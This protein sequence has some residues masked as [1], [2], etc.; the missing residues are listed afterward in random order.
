MGSGLR[1]FLDPEGGKL[2]DLHWQKVGKDVTHYPGPGFHELPTY[3]TTPLTF[4]YLRVQLQIVEYGLRPI[5]NPVYVP[6]DWRR[7]PANHASR[8]GFAPSPSHAPYD[9]ELFL[10]AQYTAIIFFDLS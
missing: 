7:R 9:D 4:G 8:L 1:R 3:A 2:G 10:S 6:P 5:D